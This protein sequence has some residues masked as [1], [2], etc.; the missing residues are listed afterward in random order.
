M[1]MILASVIIPDEPPIVF[2]VI[3]NYLASQ[4]FG[5]KIFLFQINTAILN[6]LIKES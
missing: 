2:I 1:G 5:S 6:C 3:P 4:V